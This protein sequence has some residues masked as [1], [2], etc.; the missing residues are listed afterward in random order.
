MKKILCMLALIVALVCLFASCDFIKAPEITISDD[1]YWIING[2]KTDVKAQG[3]K[4]DKGDS[5]SVTNENP[6]GLAFFLKD[7]DTYVVEI[8]YAKYLSKIEIPATYNGKDVT[9]VR[10]FTSETLKEVTIGD[11]V[12][13]IGNYAFEYC[14]ALTSVTIGNGVTSI[15][16]F[17]FR[18]CGNLTSVTIPDSVTSIGG[19]AFEACVS[20]TSITIPDSVTSVGNSAFAYCTS[21]TSI[22]VDNDNTAYQSID[23]NLYSKDGNTLIAYA[24]G[25]I[26]KSFTIPDSVTTIGERAF[27][28][29]SNLTSITIGDSVTRIGHSAFRAC[30]NLTDVYYTGGEADWA[31]IRISF[32]NDYFMCLFIIS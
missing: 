21:L 8:G 7:D 30:T 16:S 15:G 28:D 18:G 26:E 31:Q 19:S 17:A 23:G 14:S 25:K 1:G 6:L 5:A 12:T 11:N 10:N 4:G 24:I 2:E 3:E 9:E 32:I 20:L 29:C 13:S 22:L 27:A